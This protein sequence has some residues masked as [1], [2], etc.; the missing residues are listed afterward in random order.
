[1]KK[2]QTKIKRAILK[3]LLSGDY[4]SEAGLNVMHNTVTGGSVYDNHIHVG[5]MV[6]NGIEMQEGYSITISN[7]PQK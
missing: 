5:F 3:W 1:M 7:T 2:T 6:I 4:F